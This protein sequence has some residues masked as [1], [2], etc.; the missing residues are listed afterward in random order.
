MAVIHVVSVSGGKDST[1]TLLLALE[2][3]PRENIRPIFCD[4]GNEHTAVYEYLDYLEQ[5]LGVTITRLRADFS[6]QIANKRRFIANDQRTGRD[7]RGRKLRWTNKAKRRALA[8]LHPSGNP[9]LDLCLWKGRFPS[10]KAQFCTEELKRNI[11]VAFQLDLIDAGHRVI[12]WQGVRR[13]ESMNRRN[14]KKA[15]R[16]GPALRAFR[17][18]VEWSAADVF[19]YCAKHHIKPNPLYLSGMNRVGCMPCHNAGKKEITQIDARFPQYLE[20]KARWEML[21]G[22]ASKRGFSTFFNKELHEENYADRRV[23]KANEISA[24][25][26]W[27]KTSRG[28][29]QYDLLAD[30][31]EPTACA[32]SYGLCA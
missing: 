32:S 19:S 12:S 14:A 2:R 15:E 21:V 9:F 11:A 6:E 3:V 18:L 13:D 28:G 30:I 16:I 5:A 22:Q 1:A 31:D 25:V 24:V 7:K 8:V 10:R 29:R 17:P 23:H 26:Q 27:A 4:T 20:E